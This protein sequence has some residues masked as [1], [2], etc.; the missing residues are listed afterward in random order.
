MDRLLSGR[1]PH[2]DQIFLLFQIRTWW[3][4]SRCKDL[5]FSK[6]VMSR[7]AEY[8]ILVAFCELIL[9]EIKLGP[10]ERM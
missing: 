7:K 10:A 1:S 5:Y 6:Q 2:I 3:V 8:I 4:P 9:M